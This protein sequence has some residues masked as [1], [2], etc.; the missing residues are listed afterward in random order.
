MRFR[1]PCNTAPS[2]A[3]CEMSNFA[4]LKT[5][6]PELHE[7]ATKA[8]GLAHRDAR[9]SCFYARRALEIAVAWLYQYDRKLKLPYQDHLSALIHEPSFRQTVGPAIFNKAKIVKDLG[10]Q[11]VHSGRPV[12]EA[13]AIAAVRELFHVGFWLARNYARQ[14]KPADGLSFD[15][16]AL[17]KAS[18][19]PPQTLAQL[20]A[21]AAQLAE[22]DAKLT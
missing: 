19:V 21:L 14:A 4:F 8:E 5:E 16:N 2:A 13:D 9:A 11:A 12:R 22:K 17:P 6:W 1:P 3:N 10:N 20:H 15:A 7:A 18:P